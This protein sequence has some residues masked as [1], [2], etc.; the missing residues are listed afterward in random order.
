MPSRAKSPFILFIHY[1]R[2]KF[3]AYSCITPITTSH[4]FQSTHFAS[5]FW[6]ENGLWDLLV[7]IGLSLYFHFAA[8]ESKDSTMS[9]LFRQPL[10]RRYPQSPAETM[11]ILRSFWGSNRRHL[12]WPQ[13]RVSHSKK[14]LSFSLARMVLDWRVLNRSLAREFQRGN[15]SETHLAISD[16]PDMLLTWRWI[17]WLYLLRSL[18]LVSC[19][20]QRKVE[21]STVSM[22]F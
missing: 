17:L 3:K 15:K 7:A 14:A 20:D 2:M 18:R 8:S 10:Q 11:T 22:A 16:L 9:F 5:F 1:I 13:P 6:N 21:V 4:I 19:W 12:L